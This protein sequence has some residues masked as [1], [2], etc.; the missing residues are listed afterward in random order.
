MQVIIASAST[1]FFVLFIKQCP[2]GLLYANLMDFCKS[3]IQIYT[4]FILH[5]DVQLS[6]KTTLCSFQLSWRKMRF[7][8]LESVIVLRV[9]KLCENCKLKASCL[10]TRMWTSTSFVNF[11]INQLESLDYRIKRTRTTGNLLVFPQIQEMVRG[12]SS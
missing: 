11:R 12:F 5:P 1:N 6:K 4:Y 3:F 9:V 7:L 8:L 10:E 2:L